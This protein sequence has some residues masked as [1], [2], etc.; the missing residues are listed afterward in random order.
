MSYKS[1]KM[2]FSV[3]SIQNNANAF[4]EGFFAQEQSRLVKKGHYGSR[5]RNAASDPWHLSGFIIFSQTSEKYAYCLFKVVYED[6]YP[7]NFTH[8]YL[9]NIEYE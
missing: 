3:I 5:K 8:P 4:F 1:E 7:K 6:R 2:K 9:Q